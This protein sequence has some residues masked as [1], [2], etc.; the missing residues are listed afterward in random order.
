MEVHVGNGSGEE[1][2]GGGGGEIDIIF[3]PKL[4]GGRGKV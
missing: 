2:G 3:L 1:K 4:S